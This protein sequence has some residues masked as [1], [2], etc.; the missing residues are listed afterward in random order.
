MSFAA[1]E[2]SRSQGAPDTLIRFIHQTTYYAYTDAEEPIT[3]G[4]DAAGQPLVYQP[5]PLSPDSV[6]ASGT[7]DK[8]ILKIKL[9]RTTGIAE[10]FRVFPPS[11]VVTCTMFQGHHGDPDSEFNVVWA[12][13]AIS[14]AH[15]GS[16]ATLNC[17]PISTSMRR[18]GL[19]RRWQ[20]G[21]P[22]PLY[23]PQCRAVQADFTRTAAPIDVNGVTVTFAAGWNGVFDPARFLD[24]VMQ[25]TTGAGITEI[26]AI[27][28][29]DVANKRLT[30]SGR[31][32]SLNAGDTVHI[33]LGCNHQMDGCDVFANIQNFGGDPWIPKQNPIG[34]ANMFY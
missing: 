28:R 10:L 26:R 21:C 17:E 22:L 32:D 18:P 15:A 30:V 33:S 20:Y 14:G 3:H 11:D 19:R 7:L 25:W 6:V 23:G 9:P 12:G 5:I 34:F 4:V 13:R 8:S 24:G 29:V 27:I 1:R 2:A 31:L 16:T